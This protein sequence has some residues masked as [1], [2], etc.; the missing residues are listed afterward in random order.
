MRTRRRSC[1]RNDMLMVASENGGIKERGENR[2]STRE[3]VIVVGQEG[4]GEKE[5]R[6][7]GKALA[8]LLKL[9]RNNNYDYPLGIGGDH[10]FAHVHK[11]SRFPKAVS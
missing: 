1:K 7:E 8:S 5:R 6:R 11:G 4:E 3:N 9:H 10:D 2:M